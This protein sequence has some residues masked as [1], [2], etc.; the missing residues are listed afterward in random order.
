M[1]LGLPVK[2]IELR[3]KGK[4]LVA[5]GGVEKEISVQLLPH[6][7]IGDFVLLHAGFAIQKIDREDAETTLEMLNN[8]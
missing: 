8:L 7:K 6:V 4:A 5:F 2:I 1:C 3:E